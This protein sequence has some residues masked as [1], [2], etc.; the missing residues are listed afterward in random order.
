MVLDRIRLNF[1]L[2]IWLDIWLD[3]WLDH[4]KKCR[5]RIADLGLVGG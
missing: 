1:H 3:H 2:D 4:G 5:T